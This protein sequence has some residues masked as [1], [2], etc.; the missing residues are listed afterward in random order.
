[1]EANARSGLAH[2]TLEPS[3]DSTR[4]A[5]V[6]TRA[7][8]LGRGSPELMRWLAVRLRQPGPADGT[9]KRLAAELNQV[10]RRTG[11]GETLKD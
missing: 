7:I 5:P 2:G 9:V 3:P 10:V 11:V 6:L 1:M 8:E 4:L